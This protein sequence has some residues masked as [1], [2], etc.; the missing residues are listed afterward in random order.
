MLIH[1]STGSK[2]TFVEVREAQCSTVTVGVSFVSFRACL[3]GIFVA[4]LQCY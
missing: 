2:I 4:T 1:D 3:G